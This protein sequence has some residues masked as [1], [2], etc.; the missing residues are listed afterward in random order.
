M[1]YINFSSLQAKFDGRSRASIYRD[2]EANRIPQPIR[3]G[4]RLYWDEAALDALLAQLAV[5]ASAS[6]R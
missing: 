4:G 5:I 2:L 6:S 1:R 3:L